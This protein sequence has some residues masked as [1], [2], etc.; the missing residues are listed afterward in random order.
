MAG[1]MPEGQCNCKLLNPYLRVW[2]GIVSVSL[3][4]D[5]L[6]TTLLGPSIDL[7]GALMSLYI[8]NDPNSAPTSNLNSPSTGP[9]SSPNSSS[10]RMGVDSGN[11]PL[12]AGGGMGGNPNQ[13][14]DFEAMVQTISLLITGRESEKSTLAREGYY[15]EVTNLRY[16]L[17]A[18]IDVD[19]MNKND[20][21]SKSEYWMDELCWGSGFRESGY[22]L[23]LPLLSKK[24]KALFGSEE[25]YIHLCRRDPGLGSEILAA[26]CRGDKTAADAIAKELIDG[27]RCVQS[28]Q[29]SMSTM[30]KDQ[31]KD[32][33]RA[34]QCTLNVYDAQNIERT[35]YI[36]ESLLKL[37]ISCRKGADMMLLAMNKGNIGGS[38]VNIPYLQEERC[39]A[40]AIYIHAVYHIAKL[41]GQ[42]V[43]RHELVRGLLWKHNEHWAW[44]PEWIDQHTYD[45]DLHGNPDVFTRSVAKGKTARLIADA[46][47]ACHCDVRVQSQLGLQS[48]LCVKVIIE[49]AGS[50]SVNGTYEFDGYFEPGASDQVDTVT[51]KWCKVTDGVRF[52]LYRCRVKDRNFTWYISNLSNKPGTNRDVDYYSS[53]K[54]QPNPMPPLVGWTVCKKALKP[55]PRIQIVRNRMN[56]TDDPLKFM[57]TS[58]E[59]DSEAVTKE[60]LGR[61]QL[62]SVS[63][64]PR[65][66]SVQLSSEANRQSGQIQ[67]RQRQMLNMQI[68]QNSRD[69]GP[70]SPDSPAFQR[71]LRGHNVPN[72]HDYSVDYDQEPAEVHHDDGDDADEDSSSYSSSSLN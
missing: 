72:F 19:E 50:V 20:E 16:S 4:E 18:Y 6:I 53:Q 65:S 33:C 69:T 17:G 43:N 54:N 48:V 21:N 11:S 46:Y 59:N 64:P 29:T 57:K 70:S 36:V 8:T 22:K 14:A 62:G 5:S 12:G 3:N 40:R 13:Y 68:R 47:Y 15:E 27:L 32:L 39:I 45:A 71:H 30:N 1:I 24:A 56:P 55:A 23:G 41:F 37:C 67:Q 49:G 58:K 66:A 44:L 51:P 61:Q 38:N 9:T 26:R 25:F 2:R 28:T 10:M 42:L 31:I 34:L 35:R 52:T 60:A 7:P 63:P